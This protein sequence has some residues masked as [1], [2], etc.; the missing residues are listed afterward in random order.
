[1]KIDSYSIDM[2]ANSSYKSVHTKEAYLEFW[3][4]DGQP[5]T[6]NEEPLIRL[7]TGDMLQLSREG[8]KQ[9]GKAKKLG[10]VDNGEYLEMEISE[11]DKH[12]ILLLEKM[13]EFL[14]GKKIIIRVPHKIKIIRQTGGETGN[15]NMPQGE[16][17]VNWGLRLDYRETYHE[18][19]N[20]TFGAN[21][22]I[23]TADGRTIGFSITL[24]M[25][26]EY[27]SQ[28]TLSIRAGNARK[29]PLVINFGGN[30]PALSG[31]KIS[32]DIDC[33]G[34]MDSIS[35]VA[36][37][38]GFLALDKNGD[39]I[40]NDGSELFGPQSGDGFNELAQYDLD[41]NNWIDEN[42]PIYKDLRIWTTDG[43]GN[44]RLF[45]LGQIGVGA[46]Y[47]GNIESRFSLKDNSNNSLGEIQ[48]TGIFLSESGTAGTI[49][50][51]DIVV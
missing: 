41:G 42:D 50:H 2:K 44:R 14:T 49:H 34:Q 18:K 6:L 51:I 9:A 12:K 4:A 38:Y 37:G 28:N 24:S 20:M 13:F 48:K 32:F 17:A 11:E 46:I 36:D 33:D 21:G 40:V 8:L 7:N 19:E 3:A 26:R 25:N 29:D 1:M 30:A 22:V 45:A 16:Q 35:F 5:A 47:L 15:N 43:D 39:G 31:N 27:F 23:K 10:H